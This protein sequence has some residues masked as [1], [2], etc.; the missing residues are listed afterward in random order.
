MRRFKGMGFKE[1]YPAYWKLRIA[2]KKEVLKLKR[3]R[4]DRKPATDDKRCKFPCVRRTGK[5]CTLKRLPDSPFC[6]HHDR[7]KK[8]LQGLFEVEP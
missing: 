1:E 2:K 8:R 5:R 6:R 4:R 7:Q 3:N